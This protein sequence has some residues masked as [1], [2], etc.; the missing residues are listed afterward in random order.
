MKFK[1]DILIT[2]PCYIFRDEDWDRYCDN[3]DPSFIS[4][5]GFT[6]YIWEDTLIG[7]WSCATINSRTGKKI[8]N[9]FA[10]AGLVGVFYIDEILRYNPEYDVT[11]D[12]SQTVIKDFDGNIIYHADHG[13]A[14][15]VGMG[16]I[17]FFT[18]M[19]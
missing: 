7:D 19:K 11:P 13:I 15:L 16:N 17:D 12:D 18:K 9:F 5:L 8:G 2:D 14:N 4:E 6:N 1:G 10:D 3:F